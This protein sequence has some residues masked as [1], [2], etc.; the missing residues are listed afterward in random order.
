[1]ESAPPLNP[2]FD[3]KLD[4]IKNCKTLVIAFRHGDRLDGPHK[5]PLEIKH[6]GGLTNEFDPPLSLDGHK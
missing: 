3:S 6:C 2:L 5:P 4:L 1:M